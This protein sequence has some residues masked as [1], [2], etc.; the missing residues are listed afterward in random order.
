MKAMKA[1]GGSRGVAVLV[2]NLDATWGWVVVITHGERTPC[3]LLKVNILVAAL[4]F[5]C[6]E[7]RRKL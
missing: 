2:P 1:Y 5:C 7:N 3:P 6:Y 4:T